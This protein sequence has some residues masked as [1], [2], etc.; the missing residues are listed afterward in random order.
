MKKLFGIS[1]YILLL[2]YSFI[3]NAQVPEKTYEKFDF[4][5]GNK[6]LFEDNFINESVNEIPSYWEISSGKVEISEIGTEKCLGILKAGGA[7]P[8]KKGFYSSEDKLTIEFDYLIR[9]NSRPWANAVANGAGAEFNIQFATDKEM[10]ETIEDAISKLGD[11]YKNFQIR[12]DGFIFFGEYTGEYKLGEKDPTI[13]IS[14]DLLDKWVRVSIAI[15]SKSLKVYLNS[16]RVINAQISSGRVFSLQ[17]NANTGEE[18][19]NNQIFFKNFRIAEGGADPYKTL[20]SN[21]YFIARGINFDVGKSTIRPESMGAINEIVKLM[22]TSSE[23]NFEI[24]GH[25]DSD[26]DENSNL[27]LSQ[28]RADAVKRKL[29]EFGINE[30]RLITKGYGEKI[31]INENLTPEQK[32]NNRRVEFKKL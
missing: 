18:E 28:N 32:A 22:N 14:K 2:A 16:Q 7:S 29:I 20:T 8:R 10:H 19:L 12:H 27:I 3:S 31:P 5:P 17:I 24:G 1:F 4:V 23:L 6:I 9:D 30:K 15:N 21:G 11:F 26:G 25:T 13:N